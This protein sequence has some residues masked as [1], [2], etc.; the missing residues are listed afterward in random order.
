[1]LRIG[2]FTLWSNIEIHHEHCSI[3]HV[4]VPIHAMVSWVK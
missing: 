2:T 1:M 4:L 3:L